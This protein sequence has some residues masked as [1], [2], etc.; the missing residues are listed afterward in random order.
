[1]MR[2][3]ESGWKR[4]LNSKG[5]KKRRGR[6]DTGDKNLKIH[7]MGEEKK[8]EVQE[9]GEGK[10]LKSKIWGETGKKREK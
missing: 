5:G 9:G 4:G 10:D 8:D 3:M 7:S 6:K 2:P 1:L